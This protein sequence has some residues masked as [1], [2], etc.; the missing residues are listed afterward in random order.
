MLGFFNTETLSREDVIYAVTTGALLHWSRVLPIPIAAHLTKRSGQKNAY[1][2]LPQN[3][4]RRA[5]SFP[6]SPAGCPEK[7]PKEIVER[8]KL[9]HLNQSMAT[10]PW[11]K[12]FTARDTTLLLL[13]GNMGFE[14]RIK[15]PL[16]LALYLGELI[17]Q[18]YFLWAHANQCLCHVLCE[19]HG[20]N[21]AGR[22]AN[23]SRSRQGGQRQWGCREGSTQCTG[24]RAWA[25][26]LPE[27]MGSAPPYLPR[28]PRLGWILLERLGAARGDHG[29]P[30]RGI[31]ASEAKWM[32][33]HFEMW[34]G[35]VGNDP[36][37]QTITSNPHVT[38]SSPSTLDSTFIFRGFLLVTTN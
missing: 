26:L 11:K 15:E 16:I 2:A 8:G 20:K 21:Q 14:E 37:D 25:P 32:R 36:E 38:G 27:V 34:N 5:L 29:N 13:E 4:C 33:R 23:P 1:F 18:K 28:A 30:A 12:E 10:A 7:N 35:L 6:A 22:A 9:G 19:G 24:E 17:S 3:S 31:S